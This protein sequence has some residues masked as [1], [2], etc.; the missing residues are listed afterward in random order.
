MAA[1]PVPFSQPESHSKEIDAKE[2]AR[3]N[4]QR[5]VV[6]AVS[7]G[8]RAVNFDLMYQSHMRDAKA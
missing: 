7:C 3:R 6:E 2:L 1:Q 4:L 8:I 5:R